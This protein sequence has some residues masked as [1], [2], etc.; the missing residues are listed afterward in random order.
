VLVI[1]VL[2]F[3]AVMIRNHLREKYKALDH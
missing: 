1:V 3:S 2:N